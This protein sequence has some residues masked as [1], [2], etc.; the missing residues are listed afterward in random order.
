MF[1]SQYRVN[2]INRKTGAGIGRRGNYQKPIE[3]VIKMS[4]Y[5]TYISAIAI[6]II[7]I[8]DYNNTVV[9]VCIVVIYCELWTKFFFRNKK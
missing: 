2:E 7:I 1:H 9:S 8:H 4:K 6:Y 5:K 3:K